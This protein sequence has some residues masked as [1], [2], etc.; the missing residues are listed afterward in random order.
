M[1]LTKLDT[2]RASDE[3]A[4]LHL[5]WEGRPLMD[6]DQPVTITVLG[7]DS[8]IYEREHHRITGQ[9]IGSRRRALNGS[10]E[11]SEKAEQEAIDLLAACTVSWENIALNGSPLEC[12]WQNAR[13]LYM[14][15]KWI[16]EQVDAFIHDRSEYLGK[17]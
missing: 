6:G 13:D 16:R 9:R 10:P 1:D 4:R 17:S 2:R 12:T 5:V 11:V 3:G 8:K 7:Q 14:Q 15:F